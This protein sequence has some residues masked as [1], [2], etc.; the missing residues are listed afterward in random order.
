MFRPSIR[1]RLLPIGL[2]AI[3]LQVFAPGWAAASLARQMDPLANSTICS[4]DN[5]PADGSDKSKAHH[6]RVCPM[7][8]IAAAT[9]QAVLVDVAELPLPRPGYV[10]RHPHVVIAAPRGPPAMRAKAR[11]PPTLS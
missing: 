2:L 8:K 6:H 11:A 3:L 10:V 4:T 7:C 1:S 5:A 9:L